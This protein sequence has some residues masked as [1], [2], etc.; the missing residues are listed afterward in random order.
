[1]R[2]VSPGITLI[3]LLIVTVL[4]SVVSMAVYAT[5]NNGIKIWQKLNTPVEGE[6]LGIFFDKF[7]RDLAN[8]FK[9][10]TIPFSGSEDRFQFAT[11]VNSPR[12]G[13]KT[14]GEVVYYYDRG[15]VT[16]N[17]Q[18]LDF[19]LVYKGEESVSNQK[20]SNVRSL[21]FQYYFY[22][23]EKKE[24]SWQDEWLKETLPVAVKV[25]FEINY[26]KENNK[27]TKTANIPVG[28]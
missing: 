1:M 13:G 11:L 18:E 26:G 22:D 16:L 17:R 19:S 15:S 14:V 9:F 5:F 8:G 7:T 24:Y 21:K 20:L 12:L 2:K 6:D 23:K 3:E 4:L 25:E 10:S 27:F 28:S